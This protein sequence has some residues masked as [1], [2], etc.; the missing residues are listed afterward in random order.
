VSTIQEI[1]AA[2]RELPDREF[3]ELAHWIHGQQNWEVQNDPQVIAS[4][5]EGERQLDAGQGIPLEE[6]RKLTRT[7]T[8]K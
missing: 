7:W 2:I 6:V 5:E 8:T 3:L 4:I 1:Q